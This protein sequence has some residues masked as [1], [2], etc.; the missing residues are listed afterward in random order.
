MGWAR[1]LTAILTLAACDRVFG[2]APPGDAGADA[3]PLV[4]YCFLEPFDGI[5]LGTWRFDDESAS[6]AV[7]V[8]TTQGQLE[9]QYAQ[10]AIENAYNGLS[11]RGT[12]DLRDAYLQ[13]DVIDGPTS[14]GHEAYLSLTRGTEYYLLD[15]S[16]GLL[17]GEVKLDGEPVD[18]L[19]IAYDPSFHRV[20]Q[21][22]HQ[23]DLDRIQFRASPDARSWTLIREIGVR[24]PLEELVVSIAGGS[25]R[26]VT[27]PPARFDNLRVART[28]CP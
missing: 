21:I 7:T 23:R 6:P 17:F 20:I 27:V 25:Y 13:I 3:P 24:I 4:D 26:A 16:G 28:S 18:S 1:A 8:V 15:I 2:V 11:S 12:F 19:H 5:D 10:N 22:V 14:G 9:I